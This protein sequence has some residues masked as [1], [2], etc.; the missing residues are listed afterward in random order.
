MTIPERYREQISGILS[1]FD[2]MIS[3]GTLPGWCYDQGMTAFMPDRSRYSTIPGLLKRFRKKSGKTL[4]ASPRR[5]VSRSNSSARSTRS[6]KRSASRTSSRC[7]ANNLASSISSRP[8]KPAPVIN[9]GTTK[10]PERLRLSMI[11]A[12]A[13]TITS[14]SSTKRSVYASSAFPPGRRS[15]SSSI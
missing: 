8:W 1:C 14:T 12:N 11:P 5:T 15:D 13:C 3:Q 9:L 6:A 4:S 7:E 10:K 2:R